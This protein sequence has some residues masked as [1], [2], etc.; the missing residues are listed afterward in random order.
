MKK[1]LTII[2]IV[3]LLGFGGYRIF[4]IRLEQM[5]TSFEIS[6]DELYSVQTGN[7]VQTISANGN[8]RP[9]KERELRFLTSGSVQMVEVKVGERVNSGD[10]LAWLDNSSEELSLFRARNNYEQAKINATS[11]AIEERRLEL[12]ITEKNYENTYLHAPF[13]GLVTMVEMEEGE[14]VSSTQ[15]VAKIMDDSMFVIEIRIDEAD[16]SQIEIGQRVSVDLI[17]LP[18]L[19]LEGEVTD[20]GLTAETQ[21]NVVI[22]PIRIEIENPGQSIKSGLSATANIVLEET[23][24]VIVIPITSIFYMDGEPHVVKK[25]S[26]SFE[27][28]QVVTGISD[29]TMVSVVE[30]LSE[31]ERILI[32]SYGF[33][34]ELQNRSRLPFILRRPHM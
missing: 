29:D 5:Q 28:V 18:E 1:L 10:I 16:I 8:I 6:D 7:I 26:D 31:G 24:D 20:I 2:L 27:Y 17:A 4:Q 14:Q 11:I 15:L 33:S 12:E 23:N 13:S 34:E 30:G 3:I 21:G 25:S 9:I 19:E 22:V 32:N